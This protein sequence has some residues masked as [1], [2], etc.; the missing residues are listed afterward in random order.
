MINIALVGYG[1]MGKRIA[2]QIKKT[3][4]MNIL[5]ITTR[6][7]FNT[8]NNID[9]IL[10]FSH[11]NNLVWILEI[12]KTHPIA[13]ICGTSHYSKNQLKS[14]QRASKKVPIMVES[15][16]SKGALCLAML[17]QQ[18]AMMLKHD[19]DIEL[20][21]KHHNQK[22]DSPSAS[23]QMLLA[24]INKDHE[25]RE[26]YGRH[27]FVGKRKKEIGIHAIRGGQTIGE[28]QIIFFGNHDTIEIKHTAHSKTIYVEGVIDA[29]RFLLKQKPGYYHI[30]D[31]YFTQPE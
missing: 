11:P 27:G 5:E 24:I 16:F 21:E 30:K 29:I 9:V 8:I 25:F 3:K 19:Y 26:V 22:I 15:N 12:I 10:D 28:H 2:R 4:D 1:A 17:L 31:I 20:I 6:A 18:A 14:I 7:P 13:Y 23:A